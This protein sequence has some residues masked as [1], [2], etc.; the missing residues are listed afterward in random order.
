MSML[1]IGLLLKIAMT[2][3]IVVAA[4][5]VVHSSLVNARCCVSPV[6]LRQHSSSLAGEV[7]VNSRKPGSLLLA[8]M[9]NRG[10]R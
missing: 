9:A 6:T 2:V 4:S 1:L 10:E 8:G 3:T 5:V 7:D